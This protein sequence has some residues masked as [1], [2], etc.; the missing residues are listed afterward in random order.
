MQ[1]DGS[2]KVV[3]LDVRADG[4]TQLLVVSP[5]EEG[6]SAFKPTGRGSLSRSNTMDST[7]AFEA[8]PTDTSVN[9]TISVEF[10]GIGISVLNK[11]VQE[12]VYVSFRGLE[13]RYID[14]ATSYSASV[15]CKW[16]QIDNQLFGGL[17][18]IILYPS[19][20]P[21][22]EKD[23]ESHPTLQASVIVLKDESESNALVHFGIQMMLTLVHPLF[24]SPRSPVHQVRV[25]PAAG[26]DD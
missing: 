1:R 5:Y 11:K 7:V 6:S 18:P 25:D 2:P 26:D 16:I 22:D 23:L 21:K 10:E 8:V 24:S 13:L 17:F 20:V 14:T 15:N 9:M 12:M 19:V 3:S 4:P